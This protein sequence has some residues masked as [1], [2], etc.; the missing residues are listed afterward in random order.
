MDV[1]GYVLGN[2]VKSIS[3]KFKIYFKKE[4]TLFKTIW[5]QVEDLI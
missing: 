3:N 5:R 2:N 1:Y 4:K